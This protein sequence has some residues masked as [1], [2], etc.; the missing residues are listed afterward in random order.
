MNEVKYA[1]IGEK[2]KAEMDRLHWKPVTIIQVGKSAN[3]KSMAT[4]LC[5]MLKREP[6][7]G[8]RPSDETIRCICQ[9]FGWK[10]AQFWDGVK[11]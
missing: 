6:G 5:R 11:Q 3:P 7:V 4:I 10:P 2:I 9:A 8:N 1:H